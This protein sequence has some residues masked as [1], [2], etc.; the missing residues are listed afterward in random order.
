[1]TKKEMVDKIALMCPDVA[2]KDIGSIIDKVFFL[3]QEAVADEGRFT[4]IGFGTFTKTTRAA[5][6]ARNPQNG[7]TVVVPE[8]HTVTFKPAQAFKDS[9]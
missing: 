8:R 7:E 5:H 2:K 4:Y 6:T 3:V 1:M 9:L